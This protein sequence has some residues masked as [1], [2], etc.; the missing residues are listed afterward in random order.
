MRELVCEKCGDKFVCNGD[1]HTCWCFNLEFVD[2]HKYD[3]YKDCLCE[4]CLKEL[5][6]RSKD[7]NP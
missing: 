6:E 2:L 1:S 3:N 5:N 7:N 4:K